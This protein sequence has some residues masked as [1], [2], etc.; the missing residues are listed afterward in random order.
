[1]DLIQRGGK[2][3][4]DITENIILKRDLFQLDM[5]E[6]IV[7]ITLAPDKV[8]RFNFECSACTST[9]EHIGAAVSIILEE[10]LTLGLAAPPPER[11][12]IESLSDE[13]LLAQ[14]IGERAERAE[15]EK[16][17]VK[18]LNTGEL[19]GDYIVTN[20]SSGKSYRVAL[21]G[22]QRGE[23]YCTC[24]DFRKNTLGTCKHILHVIKKV[25]P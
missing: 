13:E 25:K 3:D 2:F 17:R 1:Q 6:A 24:P 11:V 12:P 20:A 23:S 10:K 9:C 18:S 4:I 8:Q 22:W 7:S 15:N 14:A 5:D 16:M 21:R 19:W